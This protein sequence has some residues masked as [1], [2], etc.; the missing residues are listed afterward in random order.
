MPPSPHGALKM[1]LLPDLKDNRPLAVGLLV[2]ALIAVYFLA[3]HWFVVRHVELAAEVDRLESQVARFKAAVE[4]RP[5]LESRLEELTQERLGADLFLPESGFSS[6]AATLTRRLNETIDAESL[7]PDLCTVQATQN[8]MEQEPDRFERVTVNVR[9]L[10]PLDDLARIMFSLEDSEPL[11]LLDSVT[12]VQQVAADQAS[13][14]G[15][16]NY[17]RVQ[18][19]FNMYGFLTEQASRSPS[20]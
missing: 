19:S 5:E 13:R 20:T 3:F 8:V 1:Q 18:V 11:I 10:C 16:A 12:L 2:I 6:A 15:R 14:R 4:R 17:G 7:Q 9:M